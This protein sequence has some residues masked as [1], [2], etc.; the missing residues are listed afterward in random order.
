MEMNELIDRSSDEK[1]ITTTIASSATSVTGEDLTLSDQKPISNNNNNNNNNNTENHSMNSRV[2]KQFNR[3]P[4]NLRLNGRTP[5]GKPRL[6]VCQVCT[7][8]FARQEHLTRHERSHTKE[9]PYCCGICNRK[10]SRR[11]LLLRHAHKI[12][13]GNYG[14]TIIKQNNVKE[15]SNNRVSK[16]RRS[17]SVTAA[18]AANAVNT[19][20][21]AATMT[22]NLSHPSSLPPI[23]GRRASYSAQSGNYVAPA[24][25]EQ[26]HKADRV[27]FSTPEL[28]PIN[29]MDDDLSNNATKSNNFDGIGDDGNCNGNGFMESIAPLELN[30]PWEFNMLDSNDWIYEYNNQNVTTSGSATA[31]GGPTPGDSPNSSSVDPSNSS[32]RLGNFPQ[33]SGELRRETI[34]NSYFENNKSRKLSWAINEEDGR[35]QVKSLFMNRNNSAPLPRPIRNVT[36]NIGSPS[37][38]SISGSG[39]LGVRDSLTGS[40]ASAT[41]QTTTATTAA[42]TTTTTTAETEDDWLPM[43]NHTDSVSSSVAPLH[44]IDGNSNTGALLEQFNRLEFNDN[45]MG[46]LSEFTKDVQ[47][48]FG[49]Y[50]QDEQSDVYNIP[51]QFPLSSSNDENLTDPTMGSTNQTSTSANDN[52]TFYG[53]DYL[54]LS[55]ISRASPPN[56]LNSEDLPSS[57]LFTHELRQIC[58]HSLRYYSN[59]C[60]GVLGSDPVFISKDLI[61]PSCS[62]LNGYSSYFQKYFNPHTAFIHPDFFQL[63]LPSLMNYINEGDTNDEEDSQY[64]QYS[65]IACLPL[66]VATVGSIYKSGCNSRTMELYEISRRVLHVYLERRKQQQRQQSA[67]ETPMEGVRYENRQRIWLIQSLI[68]SITFA[69]FADY[70][71]RMDSGMI[72][73]QV[74]AICSIIKGNF[75]KIISIDC[76]E[77]FSSYKD[78]TFDNP[79]DYVFFE[80]KIRCTLMVYKICQFL[81]I[82]YRV[83]SK[84]FL[85]EKDLDPVCIPDDESTWL[86]SSLLVPSKST[87]KKYTVDFQK[88]YHSFTFNN[89]GMH[90]IPECLTTAMLYYEFNEI[91]FSPFHVFLTRIDTK[92]LELN[93]TQLSQIDSDP[94]IVT[95]HDILNSDS[96]TLRN[97][98]MSMVFLTKIDVTFG[99]KIW[100]GKL[101]ELFTSFLDPSSINIL[102]KGS[103][104]LLT[105]FLVALNFSIKNVSHFLT[106]NENGTAIELD[107]TNMSLFNCQG[108]YCNFLILIKFILDFE[109]TPNF[110][111]LCIF[112]ELKKLA[113][114]LL[115]PKYSNLYPMEFA[116]FQDVSLTNTYLQ[117][118]PKSDASAKFST[119]NAHKL[120]KLINNVLVHAF[121]DA[122]FLNMS[123]QPTNEFLFNNNHPTYYPYASPTTT[124]FNYEEI[125]FKSPSSPTSNDND[126]LPSKS[127]VDLLRY[128][129]NNSD[130]NANDNVGGSVNSNNDEGNLS[131]QGFAERYQLSDKYIVIAKCFFTHIR[132]I[133]AHCHIFKKMIAD[134]QQLEDCIDEKRRKSNMFKMSREDGSNATMAKNASSNS[135][136][137]MTKNHSSGDLINKFLQTQV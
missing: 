37:R 73:R 109:C 63:D 8:A 120:E 124:A 41:T 3:L 128:Q 14:D 39:A 33:S 89:T 48:I 20:N 10:F 12:H 130:N 137:T 94:N 50:I 127:S 35:L 131:K 118:H 99:S 98:L 32:I 59:H 116:K 132:E 72:K 6:F 66:F 85:N 58:L 43:A 90:S 111:L 49:H 55:N 19:A 113:N 133:Y 4:E 67:G 78:L 17:G 87:K 45:G 36:K 95:A 47:T 97:C 80:S 61:L 77:F 92:K 93:Q 40:T 119:I 54:T 46:D 16:G 7:R 60:N 136:V 101:R 30:A 86:N 15:N 103:Y 88:F 83:G 26:W 121:N 44:T 24:Q 2:N 125:Q 91:N 96:I 18:N 105:D 74:S 62:E 65:N 102:T 114:N 71:E 129:N 70:L 107:K 38:S 31:A 84:L 110:K 51:H 25:N 28:L 52:Y 53:L 29:M 23:R 106:L 69:L 100:N 134:F 79:C 42:T 22:P 108:F 13:G 123:E 112:T 104:S 115:I 1:E 27:K 76:H 9:K 57:K 126:F 122:S 64:L 75:L 117:H 56:N 82:F 5:S 21:V 11:D 34:D 135:T 81:K 68:L